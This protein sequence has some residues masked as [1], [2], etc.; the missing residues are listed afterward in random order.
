LIIFVG[1]SFASAK[2]TLY[3]GPVYPPFA[4]LAAL[5]WDRIREKFPKVKRGEVWG[6]ILLL[7]GII[8][9][10]QLLIIPSERKENLRP[11][12]EAVSSQLTNGQVY[13][14][15]PSETTRGASFF[16]LG[17]RIP[18]LN[19]QDLLSGRLE[20]QPGTSL[21]IDSLCDNNQL[22]S[23]I[24]SKGYRPLLQRKYGKVIGVVCVYSNG[25][26]GN[27]SNH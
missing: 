3:L 4:L 14:V 12:F 20:D 24:L 9:T 5:G 2:R 23:N 16:Y 21:V 27:G 25:P 10:Y 8:G 6:L 1:L 13:L 18:V 11:I 7:L 17:K 19:D 22:L 26:P 15:N